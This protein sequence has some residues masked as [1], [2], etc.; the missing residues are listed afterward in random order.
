M[1]VAETEA[2]GCLIDRGRKSAARADVTYSKHVAPIL[3]R[4]CQSC[5]RPDQSAPFASLR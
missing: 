5:H 3:Q 2:D 1:S 4:S